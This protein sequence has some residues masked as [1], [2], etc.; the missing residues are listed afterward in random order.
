MNVQ[1]RGCLKQ[2][3][4]SRWSTGSISYHQ[5]TEIYASE[6]EKELHIITDIEI[7]WTVCL[8]SETE[9]PVS[10]FPNQRKGKLLACSNI[11]VNNQKQKQTKKVATGLSSNWSRS[12][13]I[14]TAQATGMVKRLRSS[15]TF[16]LNKPRSFINSSMS[17][18]HSACCDE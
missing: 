17:A 3:I 11:I 7:Y 4:C 8:P 5:L 10:L 16:L 12:A 9:T 13:S 15:A 6:E 18:C 14:L 1:H 2:H